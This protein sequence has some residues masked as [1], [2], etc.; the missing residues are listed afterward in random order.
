MKFKIEINFKKY[1]TV[2]IFGASTILSIYYYISPYTSILRFKSSIENN[3]LNLAKR[4]IDFTSV[5]TS[6]KSQIRESVFKAM[7]NQ[8]PIKSYATFGMIFVDPVINGIVDSTVT[9]NGLNVLL[10]QGNLTQSKSDDQSLFPT[11][12]QVMKSSPK[13]STKPNIQLY[14]KNINQFIL[15]SSKHDEEPIKALMNRRGLFHWTL[16]D[17]YIP[18]HVLKIR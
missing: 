13:Q 11:N 16:Y 4:F 18:P 10:S 17:V 3:N 2:F 14:Y 15:T 6:L 7:S 1:F 5:R 9:P 12:S 8:L